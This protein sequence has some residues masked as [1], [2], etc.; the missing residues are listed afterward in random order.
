[1][2]R[3][4]RLDELEEVVT[5]ALHPTIPLSLWNVLPRKPAYL[6][7]GFGSVVTLGELV[8]LIIKGLR[9][10]GRFY[11]SPQAVFLSV[12]ILTAGI[13]LACGYV[14]LRRKK[15]TE[16]W[17]E[18]PP[19]FGERARLFAGALAGANV[20]VTLILVFGVL[21]YDFVDPVKEGQLGVA[22]A[23]FGSGIEI[24]RSPAGAELSTLVARSLRR[25]ID[26][27][28]SVADHVTIVPAPIIRSE[29]EARRFAETH[30]IALV[31]WGWMSGE[32]TFVPT[33]TFVET[34]YADVEIE[35]VPGWHEV[36]IIGSGNIELSQAMAH[37]TS[38]LIEYIMG[39]IYLDRGR[40]DQALVR[41]QKAAEQAEEALEL[42]RVTA[43]ETRVL[44]N[45]LAIYHLTIGK[46]IAAQGDQV[47]AR[48]E[49]EIAME[50][51]P[52]YGPIYIGFGNIAYTEGRFEDALEWYDQAVS[53]SNRRRE[54]AY[55]ARGSAYYYL[56]RYEEAAEDYRAAIEVAEHNDEKTALYHLVLGITL[57]HLEQ[58]EEGLEE[59]ALAAQLSQPES[60]LCESAGREL[61][62][63]RAIAT[64]STEPTLVPTHF[65]TST[66]VFP[67]PTSTFLP[68]PTPTPTPTATRFPTEAPP[69]PTQMP[70]PTAT[71][72][73]TLPPP[74]ESPTAS[75]TDTPLPPPP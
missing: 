67:T 50:Y 69:P 26:L 39:L 9:F 11:A 33:L 12:G 64:P 3:T 8:G 19:A 55:Y 56:E 28:P 14:L 37:R 47:Q 58:F 35:E 31:I 65:P 44:S 22:V 72:F 7:L 45:T 23:Q 63:C 61:E 20:V 13:W 21:Q 54:V 24:D 70:S 52:E 75:F 30:N 68:I 53:Q 48:T 51:D 38:G 36:E 1:M 32:G 25:E 29:E 42:D 27:S 2:E 6:L 62:S 41:F 17:R 18:R 71:P 16:T 34:P 43:H 15:G 60:D 5:Q 57:C 4:G 73:P 40:F 66:P 10:L 59:I 49:Y 74:T 46:T